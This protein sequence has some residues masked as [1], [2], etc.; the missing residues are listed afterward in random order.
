LRFDEFGYGPVA[1][2]Y[3]ELAALYSRGR[4]AES[5]RSQ[6]AHLMPGDRV[7][8]AGVGRGEDALG[9]ARLGARVTGV[10]LS[11]A[12][13]SRFARRLEREGLEADLIEADVARPGSASSSRPPGS[14]SASDEL[15][16]TLYDAVVANYFLNLFDVERAREM[17]RILAQRVRPGGILMCADFALPLGGGLARIWTEAYYRP[18]NWIAWALGFCDLHPILDY[19]RLL[20]PLGFRLR[21]QRRFPVWRGENPA[22]VSIVAERGP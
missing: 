2:I 9:A 12:M 14:P 16:D 18:A 6:L 10:D 1:A 3:D 19:E 20:E 8:Y 11:P 7:L 17:M 5:K 15:S 13:L 22:Y 4:I 21:E